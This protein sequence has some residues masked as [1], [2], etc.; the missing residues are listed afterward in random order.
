MFRRPV[1]GG[2]LKRIHFLVAKPG[3]EDHCR[4]VA[5]L[6]DRT[7]RIQAAARPQAIVE[8]DAVRLELLQ[9]LQ[10]FLVRSRLDHFS[11][12]GAHATQ[13]A[14]GDIEVGSAVID[15]QDAIVRNARAPGPRFGIDTHLYG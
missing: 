2:P 13:I 11:G 14:A 12:E 5:A 3:H 7:Q 1:H 4:V 8:Q 15:H 9:P 10:A 6:A